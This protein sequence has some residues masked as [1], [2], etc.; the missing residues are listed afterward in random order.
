MDDV[1]KKETSIHDEGVQNM[2]HDEDK[3]KNGD[4]DE[5]HTRDQDRN[6]KFPT[7]YLDAATPQRDY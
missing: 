1:W 4:T 2:V 5:V 6:Y 7:I 3:D